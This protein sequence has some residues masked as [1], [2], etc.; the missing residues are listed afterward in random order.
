MNT[1]KPRLPV[2]AELR[3]AERRREF[4]GLD[5]AERFALIYRTNLWGAETSQSGLG[6]ELDATSWLRRELSQLL[7]RLEITTLLDLPCGDFTWMAQMGLG[8]IAY[9]GADIVPDIVATNAARYGRPGHIEFRQLDLVSDPL[10]AVDLVLCRD[11]LVHLSFANI[12]RAIANLKRSGARWLLTTTFPDA[13]ANRDI[14]DGDWRVL[15]MQQAPFLFPTPEAVIN[16]GCTEA[17]GDYADKS[18]GLWRVE[19]LPGEA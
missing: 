11:C 4:D 12:N 18:L 7:K 8:S 2:L 13:S 15:N 5:L 19:D 3:F 16:E 1:P 10:P 14:D 6:S 9:L 17:G